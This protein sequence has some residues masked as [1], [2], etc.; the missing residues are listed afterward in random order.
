MGAR[1]QIVE[2]ALQILGDA[3]FGEVN[4][5]LVSA[6]QVLREEFLRMQQSEPI[7][8]CSQ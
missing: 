3:E 4:Q 2:R 8:Q 5:K 1:K 7:C 6:G